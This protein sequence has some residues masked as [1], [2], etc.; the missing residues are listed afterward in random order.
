M[1]ATAPLLCPRTHR[2]DTPRRAA[3][4][5]AL[6]WGCRDRLEWH[7][8]E[9][10]ALHQACAAALRGRSGANTAGPVS[11]H[12]E[13]SW[14][15]LDD[16]VAARTHIEVEL[17][18]W[19]RIVLDEGPWTVPP[20]D[21][22]RA[23]AAW[24]TARVDWCAARPWA[25]EIARTI[26]DTW[27]EARRA[28]YPDPAHRIDVGPCPESGCDG[29]L[30]ASMRRSDQLLPSDIRCSVHGADEDDPHAW[31]ADQWHALGRRLGIRMHA[32][33]AVALARDLVGH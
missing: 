8:A 16:P 3:P 12:P 11:W 22:L 27:A 6:C 24:L 25:D 28:A 21:D 19:C 18:T 26:D 13:P 2:D 32:A 7:L 9:L 23:I 5:L 20:A 17:H 33:R 4:G 1:T 10:P 14:A 30:I 31:T 15:V 29:R